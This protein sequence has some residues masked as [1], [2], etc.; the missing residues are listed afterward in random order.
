MGL[1]AR[2]G[3]RPVLLPEDEDDGPDTEPEEALRCMQQNIPSLTISIQGERCLRHDNMKKR[4]QKITF[5][6]E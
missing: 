5:A 1:E 4:R 3:G 2:L 6:E